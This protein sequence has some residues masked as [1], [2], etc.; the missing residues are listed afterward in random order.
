M[1]M[2]NKCVKTVFSLSDF[3]GF[4]YDTNICKMNFDYIL[5]GGASLTT[6]GFTKKKILKNSW[7]YE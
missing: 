3:R 1:I 6:L 2:S 4:P 7:L 5:F